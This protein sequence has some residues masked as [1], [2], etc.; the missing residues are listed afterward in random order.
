MHRNCDTCYRA[1][2][3]CASFAEWVLRRRIGATGN[4][5]PA[6]VIVHFA[7]SAIAEPDE[8]LARHEQVHQSHDHAADAAHIG[9]YL[10]V[11]PRPSKAASTTTDGST[12]ERAIGVRILS[13]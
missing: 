4:T 3:F 10:I 8:S 11:L 13:L 7:H 9:F 6:L 1:A 12:V 5:I 2:E